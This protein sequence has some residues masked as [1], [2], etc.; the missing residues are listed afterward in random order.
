MNALRAKYIF[1]INRVWTPPNFSSA[2]LLSAFAIFPCAYI[3]KIMH[4]MLIY[5]KLLLF[6]QPLF[7]NSYTQKAPC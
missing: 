1:H 5:M 7:I 3:T 6:Q 4:N 2:R